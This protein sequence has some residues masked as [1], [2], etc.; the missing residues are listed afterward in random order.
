MS[1][2]SSQT[3]TRKIMLIEQELDRLQKFANMPEAEYLDSYEHQYLSE[4][5]LEKIISRMI[6]IN[7]HILKQNNNILPSDY[8]ESFIQMA[9][10]GHIPADLAD[11][12]KHAAGLRNALAHEY[13]G[14]DSQLI[15][16][17]IHQILTHVPTYLH[18]IQKTL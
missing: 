5:M 17:G 16:Q 8:Y 9:R 2:L 14:I 3:I 1:P 12:L 13:N 15:Y 6:D 10:N 7:F 11:Q 4:R 18:H